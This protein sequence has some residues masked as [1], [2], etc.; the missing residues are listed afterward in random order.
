MGT[1]AS[2][3]IQRPSSRLPLGACV[4]RASLSSSQ[5]FS[6]PMGNEGTRSVQGVSNQAWR[7]PAMPQRLNGVAGRWRG[8]GWVRLLPGPQPASVRTAPQ[9]ILRSLQGFCSSHFKAG[10]ELLAWV[11]PAHSAHWL[12]KACL[13]LSLT[14]VLGVPPYCQADQ[15]PVPAPHSD[16]RPR[17]GSLLETTYQP[18][19]GSGRASV[20]L[21]P[22]SAGLKTLPGVRPSS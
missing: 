10:W 19:K 20:Q 13:L 21:S 4:T 11:T 22:P 9:D 3:G 2:L 8:W 18:E 15:V 12:A 14:K 17:P 7:F 5:G 6:H 1:R 16:F